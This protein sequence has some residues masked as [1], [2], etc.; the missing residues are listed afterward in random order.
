MSSF[1]TN[2]KEFG[3]TVNSSNAATTLSNSFKLNFACQFHLNKHEMALK[4]ASIENSIPNITSVLGNNTCQYSTW[5]GKV[6]DVDF[7]PTNGGVV[8]TGAMY[9]VGLMDGAFRQ[10]MD[11][12]N[13]YLLDQD[14]TPVYFLSMSANEIFNKIQI[15]YTQ[16]PT[17]L[18]TGWSYPVGPPSSGVT[19]AGPISSTS[20]N[21]QVIIPATYLQ[22]TLGFAAGSY[23]ST[24]VV[25]A[26]GDRF[27]TTTPQ[28]TN[29]TSLT[30][31]TNLAGGSDFTN[32][33]SL[34]ANVNINAGPTE[35]ITYEPTNL[36]WRP[37]PN[38]VYNNITIDI[39]DQIG[40]AISMLGSPNVVFEV[41][42]RERD[43]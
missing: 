17:S 32:I 4:V 3:F 6:R 30:L 34:L 39:C 5:D 14:G 41:I 27:S 21:M 23:P 37:I 22:N 25:G 18:P 31:L 12:N 11:N 42:I 8:L 38:G 24:Q 26:S 33:P 10:T 9:T 15:R 19:P 7:L 2:L 28:I 35:T 20:T 36:M 29:I 43:Y 16:V 1:N 13:D 40:R